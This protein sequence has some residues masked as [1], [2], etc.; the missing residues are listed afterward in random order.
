MKELHIAFA[1]DKAYIKQTCVAI[2]SVLAAAEVQ[3]RRYYIYVLTPPEDK[4]DADNCFVK[5]QE[6]YK[7]CIIQTI[8]VATD[9]Q[10]ASILMRHITLPTYYRFL[11][12]ELIQ[13]EK[14]LYLDSD[15]IACRDLS[16]LYNI[17]LEGYCVGGVYAP[18]YM[19]NQKYCLEIGIPRMDQ[20]INAGVLLCNL[21]QMRKENFTERGLELIGHPFPAQD[22]DII[23]K[24]CYG[25][26]K[27]LP[28]GFNLQVLRLNLGIQIL[29]EMFSE[30]ELKEA[31]EE[32]TVI[33]YLTEK[34]PWEWFDVDYADRWWNVCRQ[35]LFFDDFMREYH[36]SFY[37]Y[38][39][40]AQK[41]L[42]RLTAYTDEWYQE[43]KKYTEIYLYGA[44]KVAASVMERLQE[45]GININAVVVSKLS[46]KE[47]E[48]ICGV[49]VKEFSKEINDSA[50]ILLATSRQYQVQIR[51]E[52]FR[53]GKFLVFVMP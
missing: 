1:T 5:I 46:E 38:G 16:E 13:Q 24:I 32:P 34:K 4:E 40:V 51:R 12:P 10:K 17:D 3:D 22:Q 18:A 33:H 45:K 50:M 14:C 25:K 41:K 48:Y 27:L 20:Y 47:R 8:G 26:I 49:P 42:W 28:F 2:E 52:L 23:N 30:D 37:Y 9:L 35:N 36:L 11:L 39:I 43:V 53:M 29:G 7:Y 19:A 6:K 21:K 44:G 15:I 31:V